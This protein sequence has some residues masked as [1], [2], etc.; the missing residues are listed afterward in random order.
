MPAVLASKPSAYWRL[1][2]FSGTTA[3]DSVGRTPA[4]LEDGIALHLDGPPLAGSKGQNRAPHLAG[5]RIRADVA[6]AT[7]EFWFWNG[8]PNDARA[9]TGWLASRGGSL[10]IGGTEKPDLTGRL[11]FESLPGKT[12]IPVKTWHHLVLSREG[13]DIRVFLDGRLEIE[14]KA[15]GVPTEGPLWLGGRA[16]GAASFEGRIDE[17]AVYSRALSAKEAAAHFKAAFP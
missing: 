17:A 13:G 8:L 9:V 16:D 15:G 1:G 12:D 14:G 5:G 7:V 4:L 11:F 6:F 10:G 3:A 2:E